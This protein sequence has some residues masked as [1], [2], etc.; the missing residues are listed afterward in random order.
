[1]GFLGLCRILDLDLFLLFLGTF[2]TL[3]I[4]NTSLKTLIYNYANAIS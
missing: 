2:S 1:M 3:L 4:L